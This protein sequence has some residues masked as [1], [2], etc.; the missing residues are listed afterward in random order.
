MPCL[1]GPGDNAMVVKTKGEDIGKKE[2]VVGHI[3]GPLA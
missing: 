2:A 3:P 1:K